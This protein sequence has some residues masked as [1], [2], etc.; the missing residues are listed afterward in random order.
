MSC[1]NPVI[2]SWWEEQGNGNDKI[3]NTGNGVDNSNI[4]KVD[5]V[6]Y[7]PKDLKVIHGQTIAAINL[8]PSNIGSGA[9]RGTFAWKNISSV[10]EYDRKQSFEMIFTPYDTSKYNSVT[11]KVEITVITI[12]MVRV[13]AGTFLMG[14]PAGEPGRALS[15]GPQHQ[16]TMSGFSIGKYPVTLELFEAVMNYSR[17]EIYKDKLAGI[18]T[19]GML[20]VQYVG[21]CEALIFCNKLSMMDELSPAYR[22]PA[23]NNSTDPADWGRVP[24]TFYDE[25][26]DAWNNAEI[27]P[28][29]NGY[30]LPTEAQWEYAC[31]AGTTTAYNTGD[32]F[33][34]DIAWYSGNSGNWA[35]I[36]GLKKPN[37]WGLYDMHGNVREWCWDWLGYYTSTPQTDPVGLISGQD[38]ALRGGDYIE[39]ADMMRSASRITADIHGYGA[40]TGFRIV[41]P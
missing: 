27:V 1:E 11:K 21:W 30:R 38:R 18:D 35:H 5:P 6:V 14:S 34:D 40:L 32:T 23:F 4:V 3:G 31:R 20:P 7:W 25:L 37:N 17:K 33:S 10:T 16:V 13:P 2:K 9:T 24:Q 8:P 28:G 36:V 29:S 12:D 26:N 15:E 19:P 39:A 41:R 22:I